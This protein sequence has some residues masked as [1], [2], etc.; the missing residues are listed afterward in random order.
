MPSPKDLRVHF[1]FFYPR[2]SNDAPLDARRLGHASAGGIERPLRQRMLVK[3]RKIARLTQRASWTFALLTL[4]QIAWIDAARDDRQDAQFLQGLRERQLFYLAQS[5]CHQQLDSSPLSAEREANLVVELARSYA[6]HAR[7]SPSAQRDRLWRAAHQALEEYQ[8]KES[9]DSYGLLVRVQ[10][11]LTLLAKGELARQEAETQVAGAPSL[12]EAQGRLREAIKALKQL[13]DDISNHIRL[14]HRDVSQHGRLSVNQLHSLA[15]NVQFQLARALRNQA[16][17]FPADSTDRID[18]LNQSTARLKRLSTSEVSSELARQSQIDLVKCLRLS[19]RFRDAW[20][21]LDQLLGHD[22]P[23][24]FKMRAQAEAARLAL[25]QQRPQKALKILTQ[26]A[27]DNGTPSA[28]LDVARVETTIALWQQADRAGNAALAMQW[29]AKTDETIAA[30]QQRHGRYWLRLAE[31]M[32]A[33]VDP[34]AAGAKELAALIRDAERFFRQERLD[35]AVS[36]YDQAAQKALES[37][38]SSQ[39]FDLSFQAAAIDHQRKRH[40]RAL[41][42]FRQMALSQQSH[43]RAAQAHLLA[44]LNASMLA[45]QSENSS[46]NLYSTLLEEHLQGWPRGETADKARW[47]FGRLSEHQQRW[48]RACTLYRGISPTFPQYEQV[49]SAT[50]R[51][52]RH[53][54]HDLS[55]AERSKVAEK[56]ARDLELLMPS[57]SRRL[58]R[59]NGSIAGQVALL[60]ADLRLR[61]T[62]NGYSLAAATLA[63][64]LAEGTNLRQS[65]SPR[66]QALLVVAFAGQ[67]K[68]LAA[69]N[70]FRR[71]NDASPEDLWEMLDLLSRFGEDERAK[72]DMGQLRLRIIS[73]LED[74]RLELD[75]AQRLRLL[76]IRAE[77]LAATG[78][79]DE[80]LQV[81]RRVVDRLPDDGRVQESYAF[82]LLDSGDPQRLAEARERWR[83]VLRRS[84]P[85]STRWFRAKYSIALAHYKMGN[86]QQAA[87]I[88][89]LTRTLYP[90]LGGPKLQQEFGSL[91]DK[92]SD[93]E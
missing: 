68:W 6:E 12:Q 18:A 21:L 38:N 8:Q 51:C 2:T 75:N 13:E 5:Y 37:N 84:R 1:P 62:E 83:Q 29:Q 16:R 73:R 72:R 66:A 82:L 74:H 3:P 55:P 32:E 26:A 93:E 56:A 91:L 40:Q 85:Q 28:E 22:L 30:I 60:A 14:R 63:S 35:K 42:R 31:S 17:C 77:S 92:A 90:D 36:A 43:P 65:W 71:V 47:W 64:V 52:Y 24:V 27:S 61:F 4:S 67:G 45:R 54:L 15:E 49:L 41:E 33:N 79:R 89:Q 25:A 78:K 81:Y 39:A 88:I 19:K 53:W 10:L 48:S 50:A 76:A 69:E 59:Q 9:N 70:A 57:I 87:K 7:H 80:S 58:P 34:Q 86:Q 46:L 44:V 20:S 23:D 11:A